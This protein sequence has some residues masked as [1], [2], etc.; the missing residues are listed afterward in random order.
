MG[1][2]GLAGAGE[3]GHG[4]GCWVEEEGVFSLGGRKIKGERKGYINMREGETKMRPVSH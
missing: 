4:A 3:G 2:P 1:A